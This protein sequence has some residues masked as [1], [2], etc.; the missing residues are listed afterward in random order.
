MYVLPSQLA[1][2]FNQSPGWIVHGD[3]RSVFDSCTETFPETLCPELADNA[4]LAVQVQNALAFRGDPD[5][6][7]PVM[8]CIAK[9]NSYWASR[10]T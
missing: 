1:H 7:A 4:A 2:V 8:Q 10:F 5:V 3:W 6:P 9:I